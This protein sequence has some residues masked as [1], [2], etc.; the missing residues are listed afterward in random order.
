MLAGDLNTWTAGRKSV[1]AALTEQLGLEEILI[2]PD[3]RRRVFGK[4][5]DYVFVRGVEVI[6]ARVIE[7]ESSDHHPVSVM[8]RIP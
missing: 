5:V 8:L 3:R 2:T 7:V 4:Q 1:V 6:S